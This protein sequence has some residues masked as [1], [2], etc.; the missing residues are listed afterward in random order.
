MFLFLVG[1]ILVGKKH[2]GLLDALQMRV[3]NLRT[4]YT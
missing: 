2:V 1:K 4:Q 3:N